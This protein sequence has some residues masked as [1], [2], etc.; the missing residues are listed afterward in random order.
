[1][2]L[3][4]SVSGIGF[5]GRLRCLLHVFKTTFAEKLLVTVKSLRP[6]SLIP[7]STNKSTE[8]NS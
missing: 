7:D 8:F 2:T 5:G 1:M 6:A 4:R 3:S